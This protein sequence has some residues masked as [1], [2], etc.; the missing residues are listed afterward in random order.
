M[1]VVAVSTPG[2]PGWCWRIVNYAGELVEESNVAFPTI[3][4]AITEGRQRLEAMNVLDVS[5]RP[6]HA[7]RTAR[8]VRRP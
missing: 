6:S 4:T 8:H 1:D 2:H 7:G 5:H 3:A